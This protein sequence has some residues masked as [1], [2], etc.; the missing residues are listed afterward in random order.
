MKTTIQ[1]EKSTRLELVDIGRKNQSY[2]SLIR[3]L[4]ALKKERT[5]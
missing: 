4:I 1:I 2:D 5:D 3:E